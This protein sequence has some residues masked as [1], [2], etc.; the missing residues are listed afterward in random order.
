MREIECDTHGWVTW[1]GEVM[2]KRCGRLYRLPVDGVA[3]GELVEPTDPPICDCGAR[4]T[5]GA[6]ESE[7]SARPIC[8]DCYE[9]HKPRV[10]VA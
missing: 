5:P 6:D 10:F 1:A 9:R 8:G 2:C 4:L 3:Q 7:F